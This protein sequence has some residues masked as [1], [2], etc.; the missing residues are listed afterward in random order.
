MKFCINQKHIS[1]NRLWASMEIHV[2]EPYKTVTGIMSSARH[3]CQFVLCS[4][5]MS[6]DLVDGKCVNFH[7]DYSSSF[8]CGQQEKLVSMLESSRLWKL[9]LPVL[10]DYASK[11]NKKIWTTVA[12]TENIRR[13]I[14]LH[15]NQYADFVDFITNFYEIH[16]HFTW[17]SRSPLNKSRFFWLSNFSAYLHL[18]NKSNINFVRKY[19]SGFKDRL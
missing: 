8:Y 11:W 5:Q 15:F 17:A 12:Y 18:P 7:S 13:N 1:V 19:V 10:C 3:F 4:G 2:I 9:H 6:N 14:R 16:S